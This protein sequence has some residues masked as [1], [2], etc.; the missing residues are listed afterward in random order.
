MI[1]LYYPISA[2]A[3]RIEGFRQ[4]LTL[5]GLAYL[6]DS[7]RLDEYRAIEFIKQDSGI[8]SALVEALGADYTDFGKISS[9]TGVPTVLGWVG[10]EVQWRG[11]SDNLI[12]RQ[13]DVVDIYSTT[14]VKKA[15][16][17]LLK[18]SVT[19]VYYGLRERKAYGVRGREKFS[20][21][22]DIVFDEG[23]TIIFKTRRI[24][25]DTK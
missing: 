8:N 18:Y 16:S 3:T 4:P 2:I 1:S 25:L 6:K 7:N 24:N 12:E 17:L 10:H 19:N 5:D 20:E 13:N 9:S 22:M 15:K 11:A 14:N 21:F 23:D